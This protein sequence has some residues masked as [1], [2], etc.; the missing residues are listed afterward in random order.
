MVVGSSVSRVIYIALLSRKSTC[1]HAHLYSQLVVGLFFSIL[2]VC[3]KET[4]DKTKWWHT[5]SGTTSSKRSRTETSAIESP[6]PKFRC[7]QHWILQDVGHLWTGYLTGHAKHY[8]TS[9]NYNILWKLKQILAG[10]MSCR[11]GSKLALT[12]SWCVCSDLIFICL[13][14]CFSDLVSLCP[15]YFLSNCNNDILSQAW[16]GVRKGS[17]IIHIL[18]NG[19]VFSFSYSTNHDSLGFKIYNCSFPTYSGSAWLSFFRVIT[20]FPLIR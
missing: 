2:S 12:Q 18:F 5:S 19:L 15:Q 17:L 8:T 14:L 3:W 13:E 11:T 1:P 20:T 16:L 6:T 9:A 4:Q 10:F 7:R